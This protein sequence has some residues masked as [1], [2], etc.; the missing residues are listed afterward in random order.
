MK[1]S[2]V[3][4]KL[5][6]KDFHRIGEKIVAGIEGECSF[7]EIAEKLGLPGRQWAYHICC[8]AAGKLAYR[9]QKLEG[10]E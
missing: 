10:T 3:P 7:E 1:G 9:A 8:V 2:T 6:N 5:T 4:T